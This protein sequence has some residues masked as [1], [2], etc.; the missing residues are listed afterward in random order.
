MDRNQV[1][2]VLNNSSTHNSTWKNENFL[3]FS[4]VVRFFFHFTRLHFLTLS[5]FSFS[6]QQ[7]PLNTAFSHRH[8]RLAITS[9][10]CYHSI[11]HSFNMY[12]EHQVCSYNSSVKLSTHFFFFVRLICNKQLANTV[13]LLP[14]PSFWC[15][16][17]SKYKSFKYKQ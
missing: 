4:S 12:T 1:Q 10:V 9:I 5:P 17:P 11:S 16:D 6:R 2:H 14:P 3:N 7:L 15:A 13:N 8:Q